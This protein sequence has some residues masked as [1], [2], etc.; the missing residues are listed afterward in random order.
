MSI[1]IDPG[2]FPPGIAVV[3]MNYLQD[4]RRAY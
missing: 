2:F 1:P 3:E 4:R